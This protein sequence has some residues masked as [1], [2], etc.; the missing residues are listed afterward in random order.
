MTK[1]QGDPKGNIPESFGEFNRANKSALARIKG[2]LA[3]CRRV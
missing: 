3:R 2:A 1:D